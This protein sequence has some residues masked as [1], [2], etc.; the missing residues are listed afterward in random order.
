MLKVMRRIGRVRP[1]PPA[2]F[3]VHRLPF[4]R[5][6]AYNFRVAGVKVI[7][8]DEPYMIRLELYR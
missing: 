8:L 4:P 2:T 3:G 6:V 5:E 1:G 7:P